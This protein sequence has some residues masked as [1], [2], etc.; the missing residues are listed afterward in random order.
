MKEIFVGIQPGPGLPTVGPV[1]RQTKSHLSGQE[2]FYVQ[3]TDEL[4]RYK[5]YTIAKWNQNVGNFSNGISGN[6]LPT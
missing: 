2:A 1:R 3:S 6:Y 4:R 5:S